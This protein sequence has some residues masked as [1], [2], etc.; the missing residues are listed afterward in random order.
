MENLVHSG[1]RSQGL[2]YRSE[3]LYRLHHSVVH[4]E[5]VPVGI[6]S[7][8]LTFLEEILRDSS[9]VPKKMSIYFVVRHK[10]SSTPS[11]SSPTNRHYTTSLGYSWS[12]K[13]NHRKLDI[14]YSLKI[15]ANASC[16]CKSKITFLTNACLFDISV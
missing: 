7:G 10:S 9:S 3:S 14:L 4:Y 13:M 1:I 6:L 12:R 15:F 2:P 5:E 11:T 8:K 16:L